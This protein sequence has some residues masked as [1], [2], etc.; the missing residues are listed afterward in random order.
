MD[1]RE[2]SAWYIG[3]IVCAVVLGLSGVIGFV[4]GISLLNIGWI[5]MG[6]S[7]FGTLLIIIGALEIAAAYGLVKLLWWGYVL[8]IA[9]SVV[10]VLL[11]VLVAATFGTELRQLVGRPTLFTATD[12]VGILLSLLVIGYLLIPKVKALFEISPEG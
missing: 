7:I 3:V 6:G 8:G 4:V 5:W 9:L 12:V 11:F 2:K 1:S 10:G